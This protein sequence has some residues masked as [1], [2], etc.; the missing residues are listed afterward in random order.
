MNPKSL[1]E[2]HSRHASGE[3]RKGQV[4]IRSIPY[5]K[6]SPFSHVISM[7]K[8]SLT[9]SKPHISNISGSSPSYLAF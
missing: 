6:A 7:S 2:R 1:S 4:I 3:F 8:D 9:P 5:S